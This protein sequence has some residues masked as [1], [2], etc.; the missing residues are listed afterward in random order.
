MNGIV[1]VNQTIGHNQYKIERFKK[2]FSKKGVHLDVFVND[3]TERDGISLYD[4][5]PHIVQ[6]DTF[7]FD[8]FLKEWLHMFF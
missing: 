8:P 5:V 2:E 1:I 6:Y 4:N 3:G 7:F